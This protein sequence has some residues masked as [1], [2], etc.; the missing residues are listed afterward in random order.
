VASSYGYLQEGD[1]RTHRVALARVGDTLIASVD[2]RPVAQALTVAAKTYPALADEATGAPL[3]FAQLPEVATM[4][5]AERAR[6]AAPGNAQVFSRVSREQLKPRLD[7]L[8]RLGRVSWRAEPAD[9][10]VQSRPTSA[11]V[12]GVGWVWRDLGV[13]ATPQ[14]QPGQK[15]R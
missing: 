11:Q 12:Q 9:P 7:A 14:S 10:T 6:L 3:L 5:D 2:H 13:E 1:V 8:G 4:L 15:G